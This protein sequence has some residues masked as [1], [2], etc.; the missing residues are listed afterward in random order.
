V[1]PVLKD[2]P[3]RNKKW[4]LKTGGCLI[5]GK[6]VILLQSGRW[7][8]WSHKTGFCLIQ[9]LLIQVWLYCYC[10]YD[11]SQVW[12]KKSSIWLCLHP[13]G[14]FVPSCLHISEGHDTQLVGLAVTNKK[15]IK[16]IIFLPNILLHYK[17]H[18]PF[19]ECLWLL[20]WSVDARNINTPA[21]DVEGVWLSLTLFPWGWGCFSVGKSPF[22][23][24][25]YLVWHQHSIKNV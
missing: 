18:I 3:G 23:S 5:E 19:L 10:K 24:S 15:D 20:C 11:S 14:L 22:P 9:G 6:M 7:E 2:H 12:I 25:Q 13:S 8:G 21:C 4:S 16:S 17:L 1:E